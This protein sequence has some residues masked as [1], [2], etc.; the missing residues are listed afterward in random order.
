MREDVSREAFPRGLHLQGFSPVCTVMLDE[1]RALA[2]AFPLF[3][4]ARFLC[5]RV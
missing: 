2:E 4:F 1:V 5:H 3:A